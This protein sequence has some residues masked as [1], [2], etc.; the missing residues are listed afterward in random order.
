MTT[1]LRIQLG[2]DIDPILPLGRT[3][4][5]EATLSWRRALVGSCIDALD[6][7][8]DFISITHSSRGHAAEALAM[9]TPMLGNRLE[10]RITAADGVQNLPHGR[11]ERLC[12]PLCALDSPQAG[13]RLK[14]RV[15]ELFIA[16]SPTMSTI[17]QAYRSGADGVLIDSRPFAYAEGEE[18]E[19]AYNA[20]A[21]AIDFACERDL[22]V[23][24]HGGLASCSAEAAASIG[25]VS[26]AVVGASL[27]SRALHF[28]IADATRSLKKTIVDAQNAGLVDA[29]LFSHD[30]ECDHCEHE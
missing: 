23:H 15:N 8:A 26:A 6:N 20:L 25:G 2:I 12:L 14:A 22:T 16:V 10:L 13:E 5:G 9:L 28:G 4:A 7:G 17:E 1:S 30:C 3:G 18:R 19:L 21:N 29:A 27:L 24:V 11:I